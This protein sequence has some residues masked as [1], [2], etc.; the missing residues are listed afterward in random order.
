MAQYK[1]YEDGLDYWPYHTYF[2][3]ETLAENDLV[4]IEGVRDI[5]VGTYEDISR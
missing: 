5:T 4:K 2:G 1:T 3:F